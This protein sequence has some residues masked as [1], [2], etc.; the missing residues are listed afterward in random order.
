MHLAYK[1]LAGLAILG[2]VGIVFAIALW[3][4]TDAGRAFKKRNEIKKQQ[5]KRNDD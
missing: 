5:E 4:K 2:M 3:F 1:I